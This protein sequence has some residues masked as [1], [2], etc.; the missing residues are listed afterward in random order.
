MSDDHLRRVEV[1]HKRRLQPVLVGLQEGAVLAGA[2]GEVLDA[3][4]DV[5]EALMLQF[6]VLARVAWRRRAEGS[7]GGGVG[8]GRH[9][10]VPG[11]SL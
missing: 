10:E 9:V 8:T 3:V 5:G 6:G 11:S 1:L 7:R 4:A 2:G